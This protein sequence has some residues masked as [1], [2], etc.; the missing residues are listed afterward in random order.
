VTVDNSGWQSRGTLIADRQ[1][2]LSLV[3]S[4][5]FSLWGGDVAVWSDLENN[6]QPGWEA[7]ENDASARR[8]SVSSNVFV[9]V[10]T[11][12]LQ[13][14]SNV[15]KYYTS[16]ATLGSNVDFQHRLQ[17]SGCDFST[18]FPV[19]Y[20]N[21]WPMWETKGDVSALDPRVIEDICTA[22]LNTLA[23]LDSNDL[24]IRCFSGSCYPPLSLVLFARVSVGDSS[25]SLSCQELAEAWAKIQ[26][27]VTA[28]LQE[29]VPLYSLGDIENGSIPEG[30]PEMFFPSMVDDTFGKNNDFVRYTSSAFQ[31]TT[32][33]KTL[34]NHADQ[35]DRASSS[36]VVYAAYDTAS[37][38]F[39]DLFVDELLGRDMILAM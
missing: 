32:D 37:G 36:D 4:N 27:D 2:Q 23:I 14:K 30:C 19:N 21:L 22:E 35:F 17:D 38:E 28:S 10:K 9:S 29:C 11:A 34:Y 7:I 16:P 18:H 33:F 6:V 5:Y 39:N 24:C 31:T 15:P 3:L 1:T 8:L 12:K 26:M 25:I 20:N 13:K